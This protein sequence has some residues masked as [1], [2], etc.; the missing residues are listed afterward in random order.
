[1]WETYGYGDELDKSVIVGGCDGGR[2]LIYDAKKLLKNENGMV[3]Y[4]DKHT[5]PVKALDF[6]FFQVKFF[7]KFT[8]SVYFNDI[9]KL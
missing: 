7:S 6:N 4:L 5:G 9:F 2:I 8:K 3:A 1:M